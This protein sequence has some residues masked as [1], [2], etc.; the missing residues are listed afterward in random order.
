MA[1]D[2]GQ[3]KSKGNPTGRPR[4]SSAGKRRQKDSKQFRGTP[5]EKKPKEGK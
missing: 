5:W 3:D 4:K 1:E 2:E